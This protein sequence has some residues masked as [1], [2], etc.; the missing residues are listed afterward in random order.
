MY[1]CV[2]VMESF[3]WEC[4]SYVVHTHTCR[5]VGPPC[6]FSY[7]ERG[8][9]YKHIIVVLP[10]LRSGQCNVR[11]W[12]FYW[13]Q[14]LP[15]TVRPLYTDSMQE[16]TLCFTGFKDREALHY[17]YKLAYHMGAR[18]SRDVSS[19]V[20]HIVAH[21]VGGSK[22]KVVTKLWSPRLIAYI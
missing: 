14:A 11:W 12:Q 8:E 18:V 4:V 13:T 17:Y 10:L 19:A 15:S 9:V 16:V 6:V 21:T 20:T 1:A 3:V 2:V 22:Y 5:I 7:A